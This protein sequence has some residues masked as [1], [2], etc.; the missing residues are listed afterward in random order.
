M[1]DYV[2]KNPLNNGFKQFKLT[3]KQHNQLFK[4]RQIKWYDTYKYYY[5]DKVIEL[6]KFYNWKAIVISTIL[7]PISI[8]FE[9]LG[10]IKD[11][12]KSIKKMYNQK[13]TGYFSGDSIWKD[14]ELYNKIMEIINT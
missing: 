4:Y 9:G 2:Y 13:E 11:S 6:H 8:L 1:S 12:I 5:N 3:K 14:S 10:N 7:F